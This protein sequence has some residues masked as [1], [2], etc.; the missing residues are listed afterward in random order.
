MIFRPSKA[1]EQ[2][3]PVAHSASYGSRFTTK[4]APVGAAEKHAI[5]TF[6][7]P[8]PG[9]NLFGNKS[10]G[11]TVGYFLSRLRR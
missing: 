2:R 9:L 8:R 1:A 10:H 7:P 11:F 3:T 5:K 6:L 4:K